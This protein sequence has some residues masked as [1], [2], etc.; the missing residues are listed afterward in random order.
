VG[1]LT[2]RTWRCV[3]RVSILLGV[4]LGARRASAAELK[5][6]SPPDCERAR[7]VGATVG[8]LAGRPLA[9]VEGLSFGVSITKTGDTWTLS[10]E[11]TESDGAT[12]SR[13][14]SGKS[15]REVAA[16]AAVV[17]GMAVRDRAPVP[18]AES[19]PKAPPTPPPAA[20]VEPPP[21]KPK[22][23]PGPP[24]PRPRSQKAPSFA[25]MVLLGGVADTGS[26]PALAPGVALLASVRRAGVEVELEGTALFPQSREVSP[27]TSGTFGLFAGALFG[28]LA[29]SS[30]RFS[31]LGCAGVEL[32]GMSGR[33]NG[34]T[35]PKLGTA[36]W[37]A[38][39]AEVGGELALGRMLRL[40]A[41]AG[42]V[43]PFAR[44]EFQL[45][46]QEVHRPAAFGGRAL[47]GVELWP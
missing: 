33:G 22:I 12:S 18:D 5:W 6:S 24:P 8:N 17:I 2:R 28:C 3:V 9:E 19:P 11:T 15:C 42:I 21:L 46:G 16:A 34:V 20:P 4:F 23:V 40:T 38:F 36:F 29:P 32:G 39:R 7:A 47:I 14:I 1:S 44:P 13:T 45:D 27:G 35:N 26:L 41:R 43:V 25:P 30:G 10:L 31:V 37:D